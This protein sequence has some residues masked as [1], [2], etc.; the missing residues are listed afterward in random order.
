MINDSVRELMKVESLTSRLD[1]WIEDGEFDPKQLEKAQDALNKSADRLLADKPSN[2]K[3]YV[4]YECQALIHWM[5]GDE[6]SALELISSAVEVKGDRELVSVNGRAL[7][8]HSSSI[9]VKAP[10]K[11]WQ[12]L[13]IGIIGLII[14]SLLGGFIGGLIYIF[15]GLLMTIFAV[16]EFIRERIQASK[17]KRHK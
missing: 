5:S 15:L 4:I 16:V 3:F 2:K 9:N 7:A 12:L 11:S 8:S 10:L 6:K 1:G 14:G 17:E 13:I